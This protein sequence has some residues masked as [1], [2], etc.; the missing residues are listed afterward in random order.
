MCC[1]YVYLFEVLHVGEVG[2]RY[3]HNKGRELGRAQHLERL[4]L[5]VEYGDE[6]LLVYVANGL[7]LGAVHGVVMGAVLQVLVVGYVAHHLLVGHEVVVLAVLLVLAR[8][9]R[10]I[11]K[12][13]YIEYKHKHS[14]DK[15]NKKMS[16]KMS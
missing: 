6:A 3:E 2:R 9:P 13:M 5:D 1:C 16:W 7:E 14:I 10:R 4:R 15:S 12:Y 8:Q 11:C